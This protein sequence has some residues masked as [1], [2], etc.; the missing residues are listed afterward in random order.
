MTE[1]NDTLPKK[2]GPKPVGDAAM[3]TAERQRRRREQL[4]A[5][6]GKG[7]LLELEGLRLQYVEELAQS[8]GLSTAAA[9]RL[10][11]DQA[12]LHYMSVMSL[13]ARMEKEGATD[14]AC[15]EFIGKHLYP[16]PPAMPQEGAAEK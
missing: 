5:T 13:A 15:R 14:E 12:L 16:A 7:F 1:S 10:L 3:S 8:Q 4:R 11:V 9:L 2:R 6:G